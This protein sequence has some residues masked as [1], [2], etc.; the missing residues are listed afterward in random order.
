MVKLLPIRRPKKKIK[1]QSSENNDI[2]E[3]LQCYPLT[4]CISNN[5]SPQSVQIDLNEAFVLKC[6]PAFISSNLAFLHFVALV[7]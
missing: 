2:L 7:S 4:V 6:I 3:Q 5:K 1:N